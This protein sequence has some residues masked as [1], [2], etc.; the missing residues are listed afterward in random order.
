[1]VSA[2]AE[3]HE[4]PGGGDEDEENIWAEGPGWAR[5][6]E[7]EVVAWEGAPGWVQGVIDHE[8]AQQP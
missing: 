5:D 1:M 7:G 6:G 4:E 2:M 8:T 3:V